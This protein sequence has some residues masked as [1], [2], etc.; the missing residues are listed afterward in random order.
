MP[1]SANGQWLINQQAIDK[2]RLYKV[3]LPDFS[4]EKGD[5]ELA[6]LTFNSHSSIKRLE[7]QAID[8]RKTLIQ[9]RLLLDKNWVVLNSE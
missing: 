2:K 8:D 7:T 5:A 4:L 6:F 1:I 9:E 3:V